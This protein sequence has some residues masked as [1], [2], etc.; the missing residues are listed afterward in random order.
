MVQIIDIYPLGPGQEAMLTPTL[1]EH[2]AGLYVEQRLC[3]IHGAFDPAL[4]RQVWQIL[5]ERHAV[6]RTSIHW[7]D[8]E[9]PQQVVQDQ[10]KLPFTVRYGVRASRDAVLEQDARQAF[11]LNAAPLARVQLIEEAEDRWFLLWSF[12]HII[13]D[14]WSAAIVLREFFTLYAALDK[15]LPPQLPATGDFKAYIAL[16]EGQDVRAAERFWRT[17]LSSGWTGELPQRW[18][19]TGGAD[20]TDDDRFGRLHLPLSHELS[21][22]VR[23]LAAT[24]RVTPAAV[25]TAAWAEMIH[26]AT[27]NRDI[28]VGTPMSG[29]SRPA[30]GTINA[31]GLTLNTLPLRIRIAEGATRRDLAA[32]AQSATARVQEFEF[33]PLRL[34]NRV[35]E[36]AS[37]TLFDTI[38]VVQN[39]PFDTAMFTETD[40]SVE[41]V[42]FVENNNLPLSMMV[43]PAGRIGRDG[44][45]CLSYD[46]LA[47]DSGLA[48]SLIAD[49]ESLLRDYCEAGGDSPVTSPVV[50]GDGAAAA[51]APVQVSPPVVQMVSAAQ[52]EA[53]AVAWQTVLGLD[54]APGK[55]D[56]F[57]ALGGDSITALRVRNALV[58]AGYGIDLAVLFKR[59]SLW[60]LATALRPAGQQT[61]PVTG[62]QQREE[63]VF[64]LSPTQRDMVEVSLREP[65]LGVYEPIASYEVS[66]P[67]DE[68]RLSAALDRLTSRHEI[69]RTRLENRDA[70]WVHRV[71]STVKP[72]LTV[73]DLSGE[74]DPRAAADAWWRREAQAGNLCL[75]R[76]G[77]I[78]WH[79]LLLGG[80][81]VRIGFQAHHAILDGWSEATMMAELLRFYE[82]ADADL[83]PARG[84]GQALATIGQ[85]PQTQVDAAWLPVLAGAESQRFGVRA[86]GLGV[87]E[88]TEVPLGE[89]LSRALLAKAETE[90]VDLRT[91]LLTAHVNVVSALSVPS[92]GGRRVATGMVSHL[93]TA[94][95]NLVV[96]G[97]FLN[98]IPLVV[99]SK[100]QYVC[101]DVAAALAAQAE[102]Q[103]YWFADLCQR[104][105]LTTPFESMFNY[106]YWRPMAETGRTDVKPAV[107]RIH[108]PFP[109]ALTAHF[110]RDPFTPEAVTLVVHRRQGA[111]LPALSDLHRRYL[112]ELRR[113]AGQAD[114]HLPEQEVV[115]HG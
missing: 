4:A 66:L 28:V 86:G 17:E 62:P 36:S 13:L 42:D 14:G 92:T 41:D 26:A 49:F 75:D 67:W 78:R 23:K 21:S 9:R 50:A 55:N 56:E 22:A 27:G 37:G 11:D 115:L 81:T 102:A 5:V 90:G 10:A 109:H 61:S 2:G 114:S 103:Q 35:M 1:V 64:P 19:S 39:F 110:R 48:G 74:P 76:P 105:G 44:L 18:H 65:G 32:T 94:E 38:L 31:V 45:F 29:R 6:L 40:L 20:I 53:A 96:V 104:N 88:M 80:G 16:C 34:V 99:E 59:P 85:A 51:E 112:A 113:L 60:E 106:V 71:E 24:L 107:E 33:T 54:A 43:L 47:F 95:E 83:P 89:D 3:T 63:E 82:D 111:A 57:F 70:G 46:R 7:A 91:V 72:S 8:L 79:V 84:F 73:V 15:G 58:R 101:A 52:L 12:H 25:Y 100:L 77:L 93:R 97:N 69:F 30:A 98:L 108:D 87:S 68:A